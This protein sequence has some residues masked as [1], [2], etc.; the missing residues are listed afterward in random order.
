MAL[1]TDDIDKVAAAVVAKLVAGGG[2]LETAGI[3]HVASA[4][5]KAVLTMDGVIKAPADAPDAKTNPYC[6]LQ[7]CIKDTNAR[8]RLAQATEAAQSA[9]IGNS[10]RPSRR[11]T[12]T[13]TPPLSSPPFH[14]HG[15]RDGRG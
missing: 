1:T 10:P 5:A 2:V 12:R 13:S 15:D 4:A 14:H 7:S 3:T 11:S 9:V 6:A 8:I